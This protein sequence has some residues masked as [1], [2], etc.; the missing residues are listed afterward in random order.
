MNGCMTPRDARRCELVC[1]NPQASAQRVQQAAPGDVD[2]PRHSD[3][4]PARGWRQIPVTG[5]SHPG[6]S[7]SGVQRGLFEMSGAGGQPECAA[8][9]PWRV[10]EAQRGTPPHRLHRH[11]SL[12]LRCHL[13]PS[14]FGQSCPADQFERFDKSSAVFAFSTRHTVYIILAPRSFPS[15]PTTTLLKFS[16]LLLYYSSFQSPCMLTLAPSMSSPTQSMKVRMASAMHCATVPF[17]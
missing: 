17:V 13:Q 10:P 3:R 7:A 5:L 1:F 8:L 15:P 12:A 9:L 14:H 2:Q 11:L 4:A 16:H 6:A